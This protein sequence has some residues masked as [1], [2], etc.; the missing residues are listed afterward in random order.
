MPEVTVD[1]HGY[2]WRNL[3]PGEVT[4][5]RHFAE[6][7]DRPYETDE[8][9]GWAVDGELI[10]GRVRLG[11]NTGARTTTHFPSGGSTSDPIVEPYR[12]RLPAAAQDRTAADLREGVIEAASQA[13]GDHVTPGCNWGA[14]AD[15]ILSLVAPL[16]E[17]AREEGM[18]EAARWHEGQAKDYTKRAAEPKMPLGAIGSLQGLAA[19]HLSDADA[20]RALRT[21]PTRFY[22]EAEMQAA[23]AAERE[24]CLQAAQEVR[25]R[26]TLD[27]TADTAFAEAFDAIRSRATSDKGGAD[28]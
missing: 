5:D 12:L 21:T 13:I 27:G 8:V 14:L 17:R 3:A 4:G 19:V 22:T 24:A 1:E 15:A 16:L 25:D 26:F 28:V 9:Y 18:E 11:R 7:D 10:R 2:L 20:I 6:A 23:V